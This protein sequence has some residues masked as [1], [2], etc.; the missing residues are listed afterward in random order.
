M[1]QRMPVCKQKSGGPNENSTAHPKQSADI[2]K[3]LE[4]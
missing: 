4:Q 3:Y 1:A 2:Y